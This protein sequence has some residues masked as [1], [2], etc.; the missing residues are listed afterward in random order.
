[1]RRREGIRGKPSSNVLEGLCASPGN[2]P[3][4][5]RNTYS[6]FYKM[7]IVKLRARFSVTVHHQDS[8]PGVQTYLLATPYVAQSLMD[9][10]VTQVL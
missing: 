5:K 9:M 10:S 2:L 4:S 8:S 7:W 3:H 1:M 6:I